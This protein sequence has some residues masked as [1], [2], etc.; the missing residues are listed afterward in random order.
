MPTYREKPRTVEALEFTEDNLPTILEWIQAV[1]GPAAERG[2][3]TAQLG[4][5]LGDYAVK[6]R[7]R[8]VEIVKPD[9]FADLYE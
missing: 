7:D 9:D 4:A 6:H 2:F 8:R 3:L 1:H 5:A